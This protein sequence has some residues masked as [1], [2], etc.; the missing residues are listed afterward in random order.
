M[1]LGVKCAYSCILGAF[2]P[3]WGGSDGGGGGE[4]IYTIYMC[5]PMCN[6][7]ILGNKMV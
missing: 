4:C 2:G 1:A 3:I 6:K 5:V 7:G